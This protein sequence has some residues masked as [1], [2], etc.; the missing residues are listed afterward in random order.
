MLYEHSGYRRQ[1]QLQGLDI[2]S[3]ELSVTYVLLPP[4]DSRYIPLAWFEEPLVT[5]GAGPTPGEN[6][7]LAKA[8]TAYSQGGNPENYSQLT[9]F[10]SAH[11]NSSW[12]VA[13]LTNLGLE[14]YRT[15]RY[16]KTLEVWREAW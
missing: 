5:I 2:R 6:A 13:L 12:K 4:N 10:L 14:Y 8:L 11:P 15:G 3:D 7:A 1:E 9:G 16:S